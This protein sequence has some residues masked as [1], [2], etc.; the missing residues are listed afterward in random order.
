MLVNFSILSQNSWFVSATICFLGSEHCVQTGNVLPFNQESFD[1]CKKILTYRWSSQLKYADS[2]LPDT[3]NCSTG[4]HLPCY[5]K[6]TALSKLHREKVKEMPDAQPAPEL[7]SP[8]RS[9]L[10]RSSVTSPVA[11]STIGVFKPVCLFCGKVE[12]QV[13]EDY[14]GLEY[15]S[16]ASPNRNHIS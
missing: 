13:W 9:R 1:L 14:A 2:I 11:N 6:F 7:A 8:S 16:S 4:Y 15:V 10:T 5:R 12:I 3:I